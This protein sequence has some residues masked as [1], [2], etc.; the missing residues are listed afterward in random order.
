MPRFLLTGFEPFGPHE[1]NPSGLLIAH[2]LGE[3]E[4]QEL[5]IEPLPE[6]VE[7]QGLILPV[8]YAT[9]GPQLAETVRETQPDFILC[10]GV[11]GQN[12]IICLE[13]LARNLDN[14]A[15]PDNAG[16]I[17]RLSPV[18]PDAPASYSS[19]LP[20]EEILW[21]LVSEG[22][23]ARTSSDAGG[24][25]CNHVFFQALHLSAHQPN[26]PD[27][28]FFHICPLPPPSQP[29]QRREIARKQ[30]RSAEIVM[31]T[32]YRRWKKQAVERSGSGL[33]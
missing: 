8:E 29:G 19:S 27:A 28:G 11:A 10:F 7:V 1:E 6:D 32:I 2:L 12:E 26:Q 14:A 3:T 22:I 23:P 15:A 21:N 24:Y 30:L 5:E 31:Q 18:I 17:R 20:F 25:L 33:A 16:E 4:G 9:A 13:R